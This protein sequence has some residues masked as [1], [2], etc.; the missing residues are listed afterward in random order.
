MCATKH[1]DETAREWA[2]RLKTIAAQCKFGDDCYSSQG[3]YGE[4]PVQD[5]LF[6]EDASLP[7][8]TLKSVVDIASGKEAAYEERKQRVSLQVK[9]ESGVFLHKGMRQKHLPNHSSP[10]P[11]M[12]D[13]PCVHC[14]RKNHTSNN[15]KFREYSCNICAVKGH[16]AVACP[17]KKKIKTSRSNTEH[18]YMGRL[19][20]SCSSSEE[21]GAVTRN[22]SFHNLISTKKAPFPYTVSL[23]INNKPL[24]YQIDTGSHY[25]VVSESFYESHFG[26]IKVS[27]NDLHLTDYVGNPIIPIGKFSTQVKSENGNCHTTIFY[28]VKQGGPPLIGRQG[29]ETLSSNGSPLMHLS[30][31]VTNLFSKA[32]PEVYKILKKYSSVFD[33]S[34]GT[35]SKYKISLK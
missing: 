12:H 35:F 11:K 5:R 19:G 28:V 30:N 4:G 18:K 32:P 23:E 14:G 26:H 15:C 29:L 25:N 31:S 2:A 7:T 27:R 24:T 17:N 9:P 6:E 13:K 20:S 21:E 34:V 3:Y 22:D 1:T 10:Q 8:L 16:L 33:D